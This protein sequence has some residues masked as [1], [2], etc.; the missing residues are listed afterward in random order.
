ME[1]TTVL[2]KKFIRQERFVLEILDKKTI[3]LSLIGF[4][5]GRAEILQGPSPWYRFSW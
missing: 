5:L 1:K 2:S 4:L 3:T